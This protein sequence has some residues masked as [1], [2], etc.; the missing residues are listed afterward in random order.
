MGS[1]KSYWGKVWSEVS[2]M[3]FFDVDELIEKQEQKT[4]ADIFETKGEAYF[5][6][7]ESI[8][9]K[10]VAQY[11]H[12]IIATGG[13][14]ACHDDNLNWMNQHGKTVYLK[15]S[16]FKLFENINTEIDQRPLFKNINK[17]EILFF[18]EQKLKERTVFYEAAQL[19]L[20]ISEINESTITEIIS[21]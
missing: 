14:A 1:G 3:K 11:D 2:G 5:R 15:A 7:K 17:A 12:C 20:P 19:I 10:S 13:G 18:I 9:L 4:I 8:I 6:E 16:P 21:Q